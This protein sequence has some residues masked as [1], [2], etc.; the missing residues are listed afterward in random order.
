MGQ[1]STLRWCHHIVQNVVTGNSTCNIYISPI[2]SAIQMEHISSSCCLRW[3][4]FTFQ[5]S[6]ERYLHQRHGLWPF[7]PIPSINL[8]CESPLL[9]ELQVSSTFII[10][11][12][13]CSFLTFP[14]DYNLQEGKDAAHLRLSTRVTII[15]VVDWRRKWTMAI[16]A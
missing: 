1:S 5:G 11:V 3:L 9:N 8:E 16:I 4:S 14:L 2:L 15:I 10:L 13:I 6:F 7:P 12:I